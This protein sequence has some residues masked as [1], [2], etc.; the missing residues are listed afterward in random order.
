MIIRPRSPQRRSAMAGIIV[1]VVV[2]GFMAMVGFSQSYL[3]LSEAK[4]ARARGSSKQ[5]YLAAFAGI[6]YVVSLLRGGTY[7]ASTYTVTNTDDL[8]F[9]NDGLSATTH[10]RTFTTVGN[11]TYPAGSTRFAQAEIYCT[12]PF[13][14]NTSTDPS[15]SRFVLCTYPGAVAAQYW[16]K[17]QGVYRD[18]SGIDFRCQLWAELRIDYTGETVVLKRF[19]RAA[20]QSL[21]YLANGA[22]PPN[23]FWDWESY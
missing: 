13:T 8:Y 9:C 3:V 21:T 22:A 6:Q 15:A 11:T 17:S 23:D 19:G 20:I 7:S 18:E 4:G 2:L 12:T 14:L 1:V 16:V 5:A 10:W